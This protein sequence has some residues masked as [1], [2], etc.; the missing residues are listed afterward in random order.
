MC[1]IQESP[2][3][4]TKPCRQAYQPSSERGTGAGRQAAVQRLGYSGAANPPILHR[5]DKFLTAEHPLRA[6][7][8]RLTAQE[9]KHGLLDDPATIGTRDGWQ[10]RLSAA[11]FGLRGHRLVR[12]CC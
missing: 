9:E 10:A 3:S 8:A 1:R 2:A 6:R 12:R 5:K 7:F 4:N 11:G